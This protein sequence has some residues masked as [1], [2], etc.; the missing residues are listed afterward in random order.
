[1]TQQLTI[2]E[3]IAK[4]ATD[5]VEHLAAIAPIFTAEPGV[6]SEFVRP[7]GWQQ[8]TMSSNA[9]RIAAWKPGDA[10]IAVMGGTVAV[11]DVDVKNGAEP[12]RV[13]LLLDAHNVRTFAE[14]M[15]P[16]G[17]FH[18]Y[19]A[20]HPELPT[21]HAT[22][23]RPGLV[24]FPGVEVISYAANVFLPGTIRPKYD[25]IGYT[26]LSDNLEALADGGDPDGAETFARWVAEHRTTTG[27]TFEPAEPWTGEPPD[28][29]QAAYLAA[30][31]GNQHKRIAAMKP[32]SGRN[33]AIYE[34]GLAIGNYV[35]GAGMVEAEAVSSLLDAATICGLVGEDG[36]SSVLASIHSGIRNG[37]RRP[38]AVPADVSNAD[39]IAVFGDGDSLDVLADDSLDVLLDHDPGRYFDRDGLKAATL[40]A[41]I[42][43]LGP[44]AEGIDHIMW[45]YGA[46]VWS[47]DKSVIRDR[48]ARLLGERSR[49]SHATNAE[50]VVRS[51]VPRIACDPISEYINFRNGMYAWQA[52]LLYD[53]NPDLLSTVQL[54]V[55]YFPDAVCP[56]FDQFLGDVL[57]PD[58]IELA[59]ELIGYLMYSG[60]PLHIA[61]M[62]TGSGRN[63]KGT[64][65]RVGNALLG[66]GNVTSVSLHDLVN[67]RFST[68]S[69]LGKL[70][71][72][73]GD[74]DGTYLS[75]TATFKAITG[76][77]MISAEHKG[78]DRFDFTPWAVP[79]FSANKIPAS[80]D[81]TTGYLSR[82]LVVPFPNDFTGR[83]DRTL[84]ARLQTKAELEGIAAKAMPALGR[85]LA[86]GTFDLPDSGVRARDEFTRRVDQVRLWVED[87]ADLNVEHPFVPRTRLYRQYKAW[88]HRDN[89][90]PVKASEFYGRLEAV[91]GCAQTRH[92]PSG[93]R[94][95]TGIKVTDS[96]DWPGS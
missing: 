1:M 28:K 33:V 14:V 54:G 81:V 5:F 39:L 88:A 35:A 9:A 40:A 56:T 93:E 6:T 27:E 45:S 61:V 18:F 75:S 67:T 37:R 52:D 31:V 78:R 42:M 77:D 55:G 58:M 72:I 36:E 17:G 30:V 34:A 12:D 38:R 10:L 66:P 64:F 20:G 25:G 82:W 21:V 49:H 94:G 63:G 13:R 26:V 22:G 7:S 85:L 2:G 76:Q 65:L 60:N 68:A 15:T 11:L 48:A 80:S 41:D 74:I 91:P 87:C 29:R 32:S 47:P 51:R 59:W 71:N 83:E 86:R 4:A 57:P 44:L 84:D 95:F 73:A 3:T 92:G 24:G 62:L 89:Y 23:E 8:S 43:G 69:L 70:A 46:G 90:Q 96:A 19:L 79:V 53:H 50:D 16:S